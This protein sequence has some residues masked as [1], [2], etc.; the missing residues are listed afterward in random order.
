M[1][2]RTTVKSNIVGLNVPSVSNTTMNTMLNNELA[3]NLKFREDVAT[4]QNSVI[5]NITCDFTGKDRIDLTRTGGGLT[6]TV[7]GIG[8]G[9]NVFLLITKTAGYSIVFTGVIDITA[10]PPAL[11]NATQ[12]LYEIIRKGSLYIAIAHYK[13]INDAGTS[14]GIIAIAS[15]A[16]HNALSSITKACVPGRL[17]LGTGT[18]KGLVRLAVD[19]TEGK[20]DTRTI[21]ATPRD[22]NQAIYNIQNTNQAW[23]DLALGASF[24]SAYKL[25]YYKDNVGNVHVRGQALV[26]AANHDATPVS[27]LA[28]TLPVGYRPDANIAAIVSFFVQANYGG[29]VW[30]PSNAYILFG[31]IFWDGTINIS[32]MPTPAVGYAIATAMQLHFYVTFRAE[33]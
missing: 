16:E 7:T 22:I 30:P 3:D 27:L 10:N 21:A 20:S 31:M 1:A 28:G 18:Q 32:N 26:S 12:V 19:D 2:N 17:P 14:A 15:Q 5:S 29:G 25:Q 9:E 4:I 13:T 23:Q 24:S 11:N 8:D 6:I 33:S